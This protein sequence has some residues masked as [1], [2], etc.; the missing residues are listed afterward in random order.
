LH[1]EGA[2][3]CTAAPAAMVAKCDSA[4]WLEQRIPSNAASTISRW[5]AE[6]S[7]LGGVQ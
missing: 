7:S 6:Q 1:F 2:M 5:I 4:V 3:V